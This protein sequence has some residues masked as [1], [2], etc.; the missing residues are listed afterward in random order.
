MNLLD[1]EGRAQN[2]A[3]ADPGRIG[4]A[5]ASVTHSLLVLRTASRAGELSLDLASSGQ[6]TMPAS[7]KRWFPGRD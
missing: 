7:A 1:Y 4:P 3:S 2:G 6:S 5:P